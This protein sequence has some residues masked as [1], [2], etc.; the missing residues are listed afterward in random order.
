[1]TTLNDSVA[2]EFS[3]ISH[4][5]GDIDGIGGTWKRRVRENSQSLSCV[6]KNSF[7]FSEIVA[8]ICPN[9]N[10]MCCSKEKI[11]SE[12]ERLDKSWDS[13][14]NIPGQFKKIPFFKKD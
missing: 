10:V 2:M 9:I 14:S 1:M 3:V 8:E 13:I 5:K 11:Q 7:E 6:P 12:K 4:G